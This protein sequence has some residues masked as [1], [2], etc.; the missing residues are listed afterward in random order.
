ME[1]LETIQKV[2]E[3]V[4]KVAKER[5]RKYGRLEI[6]KILMMTLNSVPEI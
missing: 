3:L 2:L 6:S 5:L 1:I 4:V